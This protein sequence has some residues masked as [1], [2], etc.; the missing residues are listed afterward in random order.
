MNPERLESIQRMWKRIQSNSARRE[1][2]A[3]TYGYFR[4][5]EDYLVEAGLDLEA[6]ETYELIEKDLTKSAY[7]DMR[8]YYISVYMLDQYYRAQM[9]TS[10]IR[11]RSY[12]R[13]HAY[14]LGHLLDHIMPE[15]IKFG[16]MMNLPE[17]ISPIERQQLVLILDAYNN[18]ELR[19][20]HKRAAQ[21]LAE[22]IC[23]IAFSRR[24]KMEDKKGSHDDPNFYGNLKRAVSEVREGLKQTDQAGAFYEETEIHIQDKD[25]ARYWG[26]EEGTKINFSRETL[27]ELQRYFV[28]RCYGHEFERAAEFQDQGHFVLDASGSGHGMM[29]LPMQEILTK[30]QNDGFDIQDPKIYEDMGT[31]IDTF[32][33]AYN[34][35]RRNVQRD[36]EYKKMVG[37]RFT[38]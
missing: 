18:G 1:Q 37:P 30:L 3:S 21:G 28:V 4:D 12:V 35:E 27:E 2:I 16:N 36:D 19:R 17:G 8:A 24:Q 22:E 33:D 15:F 13:D 32:W 31:D 38:R 11:G 25:D 34:L 6:N 9:T 10:D 20:E 7:D 14:S 29:V 23:L 26:L 5:I